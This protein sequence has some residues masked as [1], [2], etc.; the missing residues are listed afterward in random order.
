MVGKCS[1][2]LVEGTPATGY[3]GI[4]AGDSALPG[5]LARSQGRVENA[6]NSSARKPRNRRLVGE[7]ET[8]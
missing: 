1:L 4:S 8:A 5:P 3:A 7:T 2:G 6:E